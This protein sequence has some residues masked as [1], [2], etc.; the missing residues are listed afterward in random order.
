MQIDDEKKV[1]SLMQEIRDIMKKHDKGVRPTV[2]ILGVL[3]V[4]LILITW[5]K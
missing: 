4:V 2:I 3:L 5:F 1:I